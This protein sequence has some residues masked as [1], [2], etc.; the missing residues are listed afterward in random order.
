MARDARDVGPLIVDPRWVPV[1]GSRGAPL[2]TDDFSNVVGV[3]RLLSPG[4]AP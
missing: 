1:G 2:W 4:Q 3:L